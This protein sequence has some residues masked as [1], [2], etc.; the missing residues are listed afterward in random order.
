MRSSYLYN[1]NPYTGK[2]TS[3]YLTSCLGSPSP[4]CFAK[5]DL[6]WGPTTFGTELQCI[7]AFYGISLSPSAIWTYNCN[8][9]FESKI[10]IPKILRLLINILMPGE[11]WLY[12]MAILTQQLSQFCCWWCFGDT[13]NHNSPCMQE[14]WVL[15]FC[16]EWFYLPIPFW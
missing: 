16:K 7:V 4:K 13:S 6:Q 11:I 8:N 5:G 9:Q 15:V 10:K 1:I 3:L 2:T 14:K 12:L